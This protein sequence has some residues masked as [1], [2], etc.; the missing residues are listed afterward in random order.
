V[1]LLA[2]GAT[3]VVHPWFI[4][5]VIKNDFWGN[6]EKTGFS[7]S[8][9]SVNSAIFISAL[10]IGVMLIFGFGILFGQN[11]RRDYSTFLIMLGV[12]FVFQALN[13]TLLAYNP[14][15]NRKALICIALALVCAVIPIENAIVCYKPP[16]EATAI[17]IDFSQL[18]NNPSEDEKL[19]LNASDVK[20]LLSAGEVS[21]PTYTDNKFLFIVT[22]TKTGDGVA[23][24]NNNKMTF[25]PCKYNVDI[26]AHV[27]NKYPAA[28]IIYSG[29][30]LDDI[31]P[32][33]KYTVV[34]RPNVFARPEL[35]FYTFL[36]LQTG[37]FQ[38]YAQLPDFVAK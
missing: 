14:N 34:K 26:T 3:I 10:E 1:V 37:E 15:E 29:V 30:V 35:D 11:V 12:A 2:V 17:E 9:S 25:Y 24:F 16:V 28:D 21:G 18:L 6:D 23:I 36:N 7:C 8:Q 27:R 19:Y 4:K 13:Q 20:N 22:G 33:A 32:Y 5:G 38:E 31:T